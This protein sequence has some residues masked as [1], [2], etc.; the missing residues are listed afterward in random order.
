MN[1]RFSDQICDWT[2]TTLTPAELEYFDLVVNLDNWPEGCRF[3]V[4]AGRKTKANPRPSIGKWPSA[5]RLPSALS[6]TFVRLAIA[7]DPAGYEVA[8]AA[9][10]AA[11]AAKGE[12]AMKVEEAAECEA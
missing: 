1:Q 9:E 4:N 11:N 7:R 8:C 3:S 6:L 2:R 12:E 5:T 10:E